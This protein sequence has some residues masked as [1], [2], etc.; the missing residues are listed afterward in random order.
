MAAV[1]SPSLDTPTSENNLQPFFVLHK[2]SPSRKSAPKTRRKSDQLS[3]SSDTSAKEYGDRLRLETF[4][5]LWSNTESTIKDVL[6]SINA[7]VYGEIQKWVRVSFDAIRSHQKLDF[8]TATRPYPIFGSSEAATGASRQIFTALLF[9]KNMEFV[10][11]ILTFVDLG[12]HL[13]SHG[14]H[15]ANLT[16][17]DFSEKNGVGG[18][19][20]SLLRQ[21]LIV[22]TN[23]PEMSVLASWYTEQENYG[24]PLVVIIEDVERCCVSVLATFIAMLREWV[25]KIP[26]ILILGV[27]TTVDVL[28]NILSS[29]VCLHLSVCE[30]TLGT[31]AE[32]MDAIVEAILL[33][34]CGGFSIGKHASTF[35][36]NYF[37]KHDGTLTLFVRALRIAMAQHVFVEPSSI[38]LRKF[39]NEEDTEGIDGESML[40]EDT[41]LK[42]LV[43]L[44]SLQRCRQRGINCI[45]LAY[46]LSELKR[47]N[48]LRSS[49]VMCL[50]E[51]GK[52]RKNSL[53]DLYCQMLQS[54]SANSSFPVHTQTNKGNAV[55]PH[56]G[57]LL[58]SSQIESY[59]AW[60][61]QIVRNLPATELSKLLSRWEILTRG[62]EEIP[63]KIKELQSLTTLEGS[64]KSDPAEASKR[65][66]SRN[67]LN[68]KRDEITANEK[69]AT[70]LEY[71]VRQYIK[72]I[73]SIP[74]NEVVFY[75]DVE[76]L[77]AA[78][79]G[80]PRRR[81]QADLLDSNK[82]LKCSCCR[83]NT[84]VLLPSMHHT[85]ILYSLAQEHGDLINLHE[86]FHSFN[87]VLRQP[88]P[89]T[90]KKRLRASPSPKKRKP[91]SKNKSDASIQAEFCR[92]VVELQ[93]TGLIRMPTKKRPDY[94][95]RTAFG[96]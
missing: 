64:A 75:D 59:A 5:L 95:H 46:C 8:T 29:S 47:L 89:D 96:L 4:K 77:Q 78:L 26:V 27:A 88:P 71:M 60:A 65:P 36:R 10:D 35:L 56:D 31:P 43:D 87:A 84:A 61:L 76:K 53:L 11:D 16:S 51:V 69:V 91:E 68:Q 70:F 80:D 23:A 44:P 72:P 33:K 67:R 22:D 62:V 7:N 14:C 1:S 19:L 21:F 90:N 92:G 63:E 81:I 12:V 18:C 24:N 42:L 79:I 32:R 40:P 9:T 25:V 55:S 20:K 17:S 41:V 38:A 83:K 45:D 3:K 34:N 15:V 6:K 66:T 57:H 28:R 30:F 2:A 94:V 74:F 13:R 49:S 52:H 58:G 86:W 39:V 48:R 37:I 54:D 93:I 50:H 85:S 73:E 82:F